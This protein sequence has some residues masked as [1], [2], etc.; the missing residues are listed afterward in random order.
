MS[1]RTKNKTYIELYIS[2]YLFLHYKSKAKEALIIF[3]AL[4][5]HQVFFGQI[6]NAAG[7]A[8]C[9]STYYIINTPRQNIVLLNNSIKAIS[10][11][12]RKEALTQTCAFSL[13][14]RVMGYSYCSLLFG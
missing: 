13:E 14:L 8:F 2:K 9:A 3:S 12:Q 1:L 11:L 6:F 4:R 10:V 7:R 5:D